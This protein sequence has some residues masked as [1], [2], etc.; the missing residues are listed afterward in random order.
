MTVSVLAT[1]S[2]SPEDGS[3]GDSH[4]ASEI[5]VETSGPSSPSEDEIDDPAARARID[6]MTRDATE[7]VVRAANFLADQTRFRVV[8]DISFDVLQSDGRLLEFGARREIT[9]RRP[10]RIRMSAIRRDGD[11]RTLYFDG[12]TISVDLPGHRAF[13]REERP[14]TLYAALEHL[15]EELGAPVPL[16]NLF[17]E[18]FASPLEDQIGSGYYVGRAEIGGRSC[19][20]LAFRLPEVDVQLWVEEG[21]RPLLAR[22]VI[23]HK[24]DAG[25]PQF[26]AT[27][28]DWDLTLET[29][30][31][32]FH[33]EPDEASERLAVGSIPIAEA[34]GG[35]GS[36]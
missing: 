36:E 26:R 25:N 10:D 16:G 23:T 15:S 35:E 18:N 3:H 20:H 31:T 30:E 6:L 1:I 4:G 17:S 13:V 33:F 22:I 28:H 14:G 24:H 7:S 5:D 19:E 21:D 8:A 9:I 29:P 11:V 27:L 2:C 32:L 34:P 12:S